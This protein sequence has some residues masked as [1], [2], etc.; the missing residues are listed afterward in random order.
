MS[1]YIV[2]QRIDLYNVKSSNYTHAEG[3]DIGKTFISDSLNSLLF[4][5][6][7]HEWDWKCRGLL[8]NGSDIKKVGT[9][10]IKSIKS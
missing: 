2:G 4:I 9:F 8:Y 10:I 7:N 5:P 3:N 1:N 6:L